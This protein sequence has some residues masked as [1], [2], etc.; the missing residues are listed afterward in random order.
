MLIIPCT[1]TFIQYAHAGLPVLQTTFIQFS[2]PWLVAP[3]QKE[4]SVGCMDG[5]RPKVPTFYI[6]PSLQMSN[7]YL[8]SRCPGFSN[9]LHFFSSI[10]RT[11]LFLLYNVALAESIAMPA[12]L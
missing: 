7:A 8:L 1:L 2:C 6:L 11:S 9:I 10:I 5:E 3:S 12:S 4:H